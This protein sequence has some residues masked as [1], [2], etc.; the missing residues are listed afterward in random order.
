MNAS[1]PLWP[2][3]DE[4]EI[5][6][7]E[8]VLQS[9]KVNYWTGTEARRFE[10]EFA[11]AVGCK[12]AVALANGT[13][14]LELAMRVLE[15]KPGDAIIVTPRTFIAS[16]SAAVIQGIKPV[17]ADVDRD[18]GNI[19]VDTIRQVLTPCTKAVVAVHLAG[20]PCDM[21]PIMEL[22][23]EHGLAVIE[24]CAQCHGATY[25]GRPCGS[26]GDIA[27]WSFCQDKIM[28][29]GG[30]GGMLTLNNEQWWERAWSF[31]DHGKSFDAVYRRPAPDGYRWLHEDFG[32]NW[33]MTEVQAAIGRIQLKKLP[34]W[35]AAR[36]R[37]AKALIERFTKVPL[38]R[39]PVPMPDFG[40]AFYK[41][42][43]FIRPELLRE[44]WTR[45]RIL[46]TCRDQGI[47]CLNGVCGEIYL[48]KAFEKAGLQP[49]KRL[50]VARE[51]GETSLMF[52][53]HPTLSETDMHDVADRMEQVLQMASRE[54]GHVAA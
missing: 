30:E 19:T 11:A 26:L 13:V 21:D 45:D 8:N 22:A 28:T 52:M 23:R 36:R 39:V 27:A 53:V 29:T 10:E 37:N 5:K 48:E 9:G 38:L 7:V 17:F 14:A 49:A 40:H 6:A 12:K 32:T 2:H 44:G 35:I 33:R 20:W 4:D 46:A 15:L 47:P 18:S 54:W 43:V 50:P 1:Y 25:K 3:Y 42:H 16:A 31:K 51:L 24:D 34:E 41:L